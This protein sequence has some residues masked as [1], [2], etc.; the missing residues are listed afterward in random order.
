M[1]DKPQP[2]APVMAPPDMQH[3]AG[4][5]PQRRPDARP[6][7]RR[8]K[9]RMSNGTLSQIVDVNKLANSGAAGHAAMVA[10]NTGRGPGENQGLRGVNE[11]PKTPHDQE[12]SANQP[13][14]EEVVADGA[15]TESPADVRP[16]Y[17]LHPSE[18]S[19]SRKPISRKPVPITK[20]NLLAPS[21]SMKAGDDM[22]QYSALDYDR[23]A[24]SSPDY[25]SVPEDNHRPIVP[26]KTRT[27]VLKTVGDPTLGKAGAGPGTVKT[28]I[29]VVDFGTTFTPSLT[30]GHSRPAT[31]AGISGRQ[32]PFDRPLTAPGTPLARSPQD[33]RTSPGM[34]TANDD[35]RSP[36]GTPSPRPSH[37]RSSSYAW[38]PGSSLARHDSLGGMSAEDFVQ[39]RAS[40]ARLP[41]GSAPHR[42]VSYSKLE[43]PSDRMLQK[44]Q[45]MG[46]RPS[47]RNSLL[48]DYSSHL[49][50][51][52]QEHVAKMTGGPLIQMDERTRT[53][54]PSIGLIGAIEAREQEKKNMK[55]GLAGHMVQSAI[56]QRQAAERQGGA[57]LS[58]YNAVVDPRQHGQW[59]EPQL[60]AYWAG[61]T[62]QQP[63]QSWSSQAWSNQPGWSYQPYMQAQQ[64]QQSQFQ[65]PGQTYDAR[66]GGA[67]AP[68]G[69]Y[70][71]R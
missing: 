58:S 20:S 62:Q 10:W 4:D 35:Q 2:P 42:S 30:P 70:A 56:A 24:S 65:Q 36:V 41:Q 49:T 33:V 7:L 45:S 64:W 22:S 19:I 57:Q 11:N 53:P 31:A 51:R 29:P 66:F 47:S 43:Q 38:Q 44:R 28:D 68:Q 67:Y 14:S 9:S 69:G 15:F 63:Q 52:E 12:M 61:P 59:P 39:Q 16:E 17:S 46:S 6:D 48:M 21:T 8:E 71:Q 25:D 13:V 3:Q 60:S 23:A 50:A 55:A 26:P 1:S 27:G 37:H 54:D 40:V 32:S 5:V 18:H 34:P